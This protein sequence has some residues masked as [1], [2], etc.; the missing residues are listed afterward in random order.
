MSYIGTR[1]TDGVRTRPLNERELTQDLNVASDD[2]G[3]VKVGTDS[4]Y[5]GEV[6]LAKDSDLEALDTRVETAESKLTGIEDGATVDQTGAEIKALYEAELDTNALTDVRAAKVDATTL[7][8]KGITDAYTK[9]EVDAIADAQN[10]ANEISYVNTTSGL[11]ATDTQAAID[12]VE[13]RLDT[14]ESK[15]TGV[16]VGA[17]ADQLASEVPVTAVGNLAAT[18]VQAGLEELQADV[19]RIDQDIVTVDGNA[20]AYSIALG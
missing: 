12:E 6:T 2:Y 3:K 19:D 7:G 10:E 18:D 13:D 5:V 11:T 20:I 15:L 1:D 9:V 16:E 14:A 8:G 4:T 17:T